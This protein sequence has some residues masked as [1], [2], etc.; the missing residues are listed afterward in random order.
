MVSNQLH[1][2]RNTANRIARLNH[3][4]MELAVSALGASSMTFGFA[5]PFVLLL[6][7]MAVECKKAPGKEDGR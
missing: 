4:F 6:G 3:L 2:Y 7:A 1:T 5:E